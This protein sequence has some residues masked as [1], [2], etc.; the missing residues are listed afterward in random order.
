MLSVFVSVILLAPGVAQA[1]IERIEDDGF[2]KRGLNI[3]TG[4]E[5]YSLLPGKTVTVTL[6]GQFVDLATA[7][8]VTGPAGV[9]ASGVGTASSSKTI[10]LTVTNNATPGVRTL[11]LRY[12][13]ETSGPDTLELVVLRPGIIGNITAPTPTEPFRFADFRIAGTNLENADVHVKSYGSGGNFAARILSSSPT[14]VVVSLQSRTANVRINGVM[15][16][17]DKAGGK[18]CALDARYCYQKASGGSD[19]TFSVVGPNFVSL[20]AALKEDT[21]DYQAWSE[22]IIEENVLKIIVTL[23]EAAK[24]G[25]EQIFWQV[26]PATSFVPA[27]GSST[28]YSSSGVNSVT[29]PAGQTRQELRIKLE[30]LPAGC[31]SQGC[32]AQVQAKT[33][34]Q[35]EYLIQTFQMIPGTPLSPTTRPRIP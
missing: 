20:I 22:N 24:T 3:C 6:L 18:A 12:L 27:V 32:V 4:T 5:P 17:F 11:K 25:G 13:V 30:R 19:I 29:V 21:P 34:G 28:T 15:R 16:L 31:P 8:E 1:T 9:S 26:T 14:E 2:C 7:V 35:P 23:K 10:R 33:Q